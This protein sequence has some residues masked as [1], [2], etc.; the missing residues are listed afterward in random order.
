MG[1]RISLS[2]FDVI[3]RLPDYSTCLRDALVAVNRYARIVSDGV[4]MELLESGEHAQIKLHLRRVDTQHSQLAA[5]LFAVWLLRVIR[6]FIGDGALPLRVLFSYPR[7]QHHAEYSRV[8]GGS[9]RFSQPVNAVEFPRA[10][11]DQPS[12]DQASELLGYLVSRA[13]LLL[14][15][16]DREISATERVKR[17]IASQAQLQQPTLEHAAHDLGVSARSLRRRL[18]HERTQF[19]VLVDTA[20]TSLAKRMLQEQERGIQDIAYAVGFRTPAAFSR[21]FERWVGVGPKAYR[22]AATSP[23]DP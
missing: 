12:P 5:E 13:E 21:A 18:A 17:W 9:E 3:G 4:R 10:W 22:K 2:S 15:R 16:A 8:F 20:R 19:S 23:S 6:S 11:L 14:A 7:P 1:A